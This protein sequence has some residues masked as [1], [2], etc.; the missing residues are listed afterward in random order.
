[1]GMRVT[2]VPTV[3]S[4]DWKAIMSGSAQ[5]FHHSLHFLDFIQNHHRRGHDLGYGLI[6]QQT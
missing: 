6:V 3:F 4:N 1:M 2:A 5:H